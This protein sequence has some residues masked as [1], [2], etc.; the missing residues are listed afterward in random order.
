M[1]SI[2]QSNN[3]ISIAITTRNNKKRLYC[4]PLKC[5]MLKANAWES[6]PINSWLS[7]FKWRIFHS[8]AWSRRAL[9]RRHLWFILEFLSNTIQ[10]LIPILVFLL[11]TMQVLLPILVFLSITVQELLRI[12][13]SLSITAEAVD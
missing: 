6:G 9:S 11:S 1:S 12:L 8:P 7:K 4:Y 3:E 5:V 13:L 2:N 10:E